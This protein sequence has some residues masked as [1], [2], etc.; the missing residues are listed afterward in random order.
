[1]QKLLILSVI[2]I[3]FL[4]SCNN[5]P[6]KENIVGKI[7]PNSNNKILFSC[8]PKELVTV[9]IYFNGKIQDIPFENSNELGL[10]QKILQ[11]NL[12]PQD[13]LEVIFI[14]RGTEYILL[15]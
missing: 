11:I 7:L 3:I 5:S 15:N 13:T 9:P 1:M 12:H 8:N 2:L 10:A 4:T 6:K 14:K